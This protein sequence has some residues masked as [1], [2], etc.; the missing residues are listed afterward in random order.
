MKQT[1]RGLRSALIWLVF[2]ITLLVMLLPALAGHTLSVLFD[3]LLDA[4]F[5]AMRWSE[6]S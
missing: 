5:A 6:D 1:L 3:K 2:S 4:A